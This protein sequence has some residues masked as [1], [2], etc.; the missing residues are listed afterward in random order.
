MIDKLLS[1]A[2]RNKLGVVFDKSK[3]IY[4]IDEEIFELTSGCEDLT[5]HL[6]LGFVLVK[7]EVN[8]TQ[9][10]EVSF[11]YGNSLVR[12]NKDELQA[13]IEMLE[14]LNND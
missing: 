4:F 14:N 9:R 10:Y 8:N 11:Y 13:I 12:Y 2:I 7:N 3:N 5:D 6:V 1:F